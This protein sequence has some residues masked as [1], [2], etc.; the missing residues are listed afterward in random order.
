MRRSGF[1][2]ST[3]QTLRYLRFLEEFEPGAYLENVPVCFLGDG[4]V[5]RQS[6]GSLMNTAIM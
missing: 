2:R 6:C 5:F 4:K 1:G 3:Q